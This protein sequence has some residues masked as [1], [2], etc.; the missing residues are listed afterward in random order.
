MIRKDRYRQEAHFDSLVVSPVVLDGRGRSRSL[1]EVT[2]QRLRHFIA[3]RPDSFQRTTRV[4]TLIGF[5]EISN[6]DVVMIHQGHFAVMALS[7][8][9]TGRLHRAIDLF[10]LR[11]IIVYIVSS[12]VAD[13]IATAEVNIT[14]HESSVHSHRRSVACS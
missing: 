7:S 8:A 2:L 13:F 14:Q 1:I 4:T 10:V 11:F 9:N 3:L 6:F 5:D 12:G